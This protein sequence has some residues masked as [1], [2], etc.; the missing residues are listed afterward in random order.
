MLI[1]LLAQ[2]PLA[3]VVLVTVLTFS[4][5][6]HELGHGVAAY[7]FGDDTARRMGRLTL[8]PLKHLDP[9]GVLLLLFVGVGWAKPVPI[10]TT[11][12]RPYRAGLFAVSIAGIV[13]NLTLAAL[14]GFL[15]Y[16]LKEAQPQAVYLALVEG[17]P[18][19]WAGLLSLV[20]FYAGLINLI[21]ALFNLVPVPPLDGSRILMALVPV[22]YH[23]LIWQ[24]DRYAL[25][26]F[27]LII[28]DMQLN[29]PISRM[30]DWAQGLY[31]HAIFG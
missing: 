2:D 15:L 8:N 4:L 23:P 13:I 26:T 1:Q 19:G 29:G 25:Y 16:A 17:Q 30:L 11:R 18:A 31:F 20:A 7:L 22:R 10:D 21:L 27:V 9:M 28:A 5:V 14:F 3:F 6:L 24:L 12:L